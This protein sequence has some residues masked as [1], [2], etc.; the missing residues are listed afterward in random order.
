VLRPQAI[1]VLGCDP[2]AEPVTTVAKRT[3]KIRNV[4][5]GPGGVAISRILRNT[6]SP[7]R[8]IAFPQIAGL[9]TIEEGLVPSKDNSLSKTAAT[10]KA[11]N[12][13]SV[14]LN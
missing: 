2:A 11:S 13:D 1:T 9:L 10:R 8:S 5:G 7:H 14:H 4:D 12:T 6:K 3:A